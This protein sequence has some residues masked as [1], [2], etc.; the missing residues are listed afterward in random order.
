MEARADLQFLSGSDLMFPCH[1]DERGLEK[2]L[3][4]EAGTKVP[5]I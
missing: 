4:A 3:E 2:G 5:E 1:C